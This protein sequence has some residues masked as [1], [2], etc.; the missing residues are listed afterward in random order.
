MVFPRTASPT[1]NNPWPGKKYVFLQTHLLQLFLT[2]SWDTT[3][4]VLVS[5]K[6]RKQ[7]TRQR[8]GP[9]KGALSAQKFPQGSKTKTRELLEGTEE[10]NIF[11]HGGVIALPTRQINYFSYKKQTEKNELVST[12]DQCLCHFC[13]QGACGVRRSNRRHPS[14]CCQRGP[15]GWRSLGQEFAYSGTGLIINIIFICLIFHNLNWPSIK[16]SIPWPCSIFSGV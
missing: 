5:L 8:W 10:Y 11:P 1:N 9:L 3:D 13:R 4:G 16:R 6:F 15:E 2:M 14:P 7:C 12:P